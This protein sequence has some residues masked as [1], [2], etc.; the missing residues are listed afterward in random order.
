MCCHGH[1]EVW[2]AHDDSRKGACVSHD[3]IRGDNLLAEGG[4]EILVGKLIT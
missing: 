1:H 4:A 3:A 2:E